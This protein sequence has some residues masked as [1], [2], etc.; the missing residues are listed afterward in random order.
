MGAAGGLRGNAMNTNK[1]DPEAWLGITE[2]EPPVWPRLE[3]QASRND[4]PAAALLA[5]KSTLETHRAAGLDIYDQL[6]RLE[7]A[8]DKLTLEIIAIKEEGST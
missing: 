1:C 2:H 7:R 8:V 6:D 5:L 4:Y 3:W